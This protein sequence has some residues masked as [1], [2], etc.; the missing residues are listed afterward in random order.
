MTDLHVKYRPEN[1][2]EV[3]GQD[4]VVN[5]LQA[6]F[7]QKTFPH[8]YLLTGGSGVGKTSLARIIASML[9]CDSHNITEIDA[10]SFGKVEDIRELV[11][12]LQYA[13]FG[14]NPTKFIIID[15][16]HAVTKAAWQTFLK[17]IEEPPAHVYF[18]FCTTEADKVPD[19]IKTRCHTYHLKD[20]EYDDLYELIL[21]V[22]EAEEIT[23]DKEGKG[24]QLIAKSA[25]G[26]PRRALTFLSKCRGCK[27]IEDV[28][29]ILEEPDEDGEVI[30][31]CRMLIGRTKPTWKNTM[32][33][34]NSLQA[35]SP[36]S[37]RLIVVNYMAKVGL[38]AR[39]DADALKVLNVL[40]SF[41]KPYNQSEKFA[42]LLLSLGEIIF[43]ED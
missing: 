12:S 41:N 5:S 23:L 39:T 2:D 43:S 8:A 35:Q 9:N 16:S 30:E 38:N 6:L 19:T 22:A 1:F 36:E 37:I 15:E 28:R 29:L 25:M 33:I 13:T 42:P 26:S 32:R 11:A 40:A 3:V 7:K 14:D 20:V 31:L 24:F 17:T 10:A 4:H 18:A 27:K 34:L 21:A